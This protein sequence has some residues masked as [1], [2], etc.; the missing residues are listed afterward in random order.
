MLDRLRSSLARWAFLGLARDRFGFRRVEGPWWTIYLLDGSDEDQQLL[1]SDLVRVRPSE[2]QRV[3]E[4]DFG[5]TQ[6]LARGKVPVFYLPPRL[7]DPA[8]LLKTLGVAKVEWGAER[9]L[10]FYETG[11]RTVLV[12]GYLGAVDF[13]ASL[14]HELCHAYC[15]AVLDSAGAVLWAF[16]GYAEITTSRVMTLCGDR[17]GASALERALDTVSSFLRCGGI[18]PCRDLMLLSDES[19]DLRNGEYEV[20]EAHCTAFMLFLLTLGRENPSLL[21]ACKKAVVGRK[22][23]PE[24]ILSEIDRCTGQNAEQL[25]RKFVAFCLCTNQNATL[26]SWKMAAEQLGLRPDAP[27]FG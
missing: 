11:S 14:I 3:V 2:I 4:L 23:D 13:R 6:G 1:Q 5:E 12:T 18:R 9:C 10:G 22:T 19:P 15:H 8:S 21:V 25:H 24:N 20:F 17:G 7:G 27:L 16:E 26:P